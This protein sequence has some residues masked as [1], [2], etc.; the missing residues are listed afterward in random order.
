MVCSQE[1]VAVSYGR[2]LRYF[3]RLVREDENTMVLRFFERRADG[4]YELNHK[5]EEHVE[6][7]L[8]F[9]RNVIIIVRWK[10]VGRFEIAQEK[11]VRKRHED[12]WKTI[13]LRENVKEYG[14]LY[15]V[16]IVTL[17]SI[18]IRDFMRY[19]S[20]VILSPQVVA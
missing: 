15:D 7:K 8:V 11:E 9:M 4:L 12:F 2:D 19:A 5:K 6:K 16:I 3:A 18:V 17:I 10:G 1:W 13:R 20:A 14:L